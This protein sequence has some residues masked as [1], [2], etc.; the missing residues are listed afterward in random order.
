MKHTLTYFKDNNSKVDIK[1]RDV[2]MT[3]LDPKEMETIKPFARVY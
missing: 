2:V 3:T 1:Y